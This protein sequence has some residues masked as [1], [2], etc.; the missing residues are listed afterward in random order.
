MQIKNTGP[1]QDGFAMPGEFEIH[2][3]TYML[4][5]DRP[6]NWR[7][8]AKPAQRVFAEIAAVIS[9]YE[10]VTVGVNAAQ[11]DNARA[12]LPG[13]V[14]VVEVSSN[15][16]WLRDTGPT[17][18]RNND[19]AVRGVDWR[20]NAWGGLVD[21]L[22]F[23]WDRDDQVARKLCE[24]DGFDYY[25]LEDTV[26]EGGA[27]HVD[28]EGTAVV[29]EACLL[30]GGRNPHM[31]R[32]ALEETLKEYLNIKKV[33]WLRHG[34]YMD[35]T[36]EHVDNV[37]AFVRPGE[38]VLA[39]TDRR[40]DPQYEFSRS[41]LEVLRNARDAMGRRLKVQP[42]A[43]PAPKF[44]TR[45]EADGVDSTNRMRPRQQGDR[46]AASYVNF[47]VCNGAVIAPAFDDPMDASARR[48]LQALY[49]DRQ[50]HQIYT[51]DILLGGGNIHC[52]TQQLPTR[53]APGRPG[54]L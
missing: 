23:P 49:P 48:T 5:P 32:E 42:L 1:R 54:I 15:D 9:K 44:V 18:V 11:Y 47:Y 38:V 34:I 50:V 46:L 40:D 43:L 6:D 12:M 2:A 30:S 45:E 53:W 33:I 28:G 4:W 22:Y 25:S 52:I 39:W 26:L 35:E 7:N 10:P 17:F 20:F 37:C 24:M 27:F 29:T 36:N 41:C 3:G 31:T 21:G 13:R 16:A 14:R 19:G 8:G 51:R